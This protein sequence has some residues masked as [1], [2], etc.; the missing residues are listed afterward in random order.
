MLKALQEVEGEWNRKRNGNEPRQG[1]DFMQG[2]RER[3]KKQNTQGARLKTAHSQKS[4]ESVKE[5]KEG[6]EGEKQRKVEAS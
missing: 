2:P 4:K 3:D 6:G 1:V 5:Q